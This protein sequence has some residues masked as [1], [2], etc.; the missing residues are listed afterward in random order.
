LSFAR[1]DQAYSICSTSNVMLPKYM[2]MSAKYIW[3]NCKD[4]EVPYSNRLDV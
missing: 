2:E 1:T 3:I 4:P